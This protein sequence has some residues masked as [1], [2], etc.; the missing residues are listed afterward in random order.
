MAMKEF[1]LLL[2]HRGEESP[3][4]LPCKEEY[5]DQYFTFLVSK[6][7]KNSAQKKAILTGHWQGV[8]S[9]FISLEW[10]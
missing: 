6:S 1:L 2:V 5:Y 3:L 10:R 7:I 9:D 8:L 4:T